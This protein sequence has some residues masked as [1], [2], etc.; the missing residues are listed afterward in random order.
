M[1]V[2][3][4]FLVV[5]AAVLAAPAPAAG[6][7]TPE[8][9]ADRA[10]AAHAAGD[11]AALATIANAQDP[12]A[13]FV[14]EK[15]L[16]DG[17]VE[18]A[19]AL[20][21][22]R[23]NFER[24]SLEAYVAWRAENPARAAVLAAIRE[25]EALPEPAPFLARIE[26]LLAEGRGVSHVAL[27][28]IRTAAVARLERGVGALGEAMLASA[29]AADELGWHWRAF[30]SYRAAFQ[31]FYTVNAADK[32]ARIARAMLRLAQ[33]SKDETEGF[34][35]HQMEAF[36]LQTLGQVER[37]LEHA[38]KS[39]AYAQNKHETRNALRVVIMMHI[40]LGNAH[41][42]LRKLKRLNQLDHELGD[43]RGAVISSTQLARYEA[44]VGRLAQALARIEGVLAYTKR[45]GGAHADVYAAHMH[46]SQIT[47]TLGDPK[48][49][50]EHIKLARAAE[51]RSREA[52]EPVNYD[53]FQLD[54]SE[55]L[56]LA[57]MER[58]EEAAVLSR[59]VVEGRTR[60]PPAMRL[61]D[62]IALAIDL[63]YLGRHEE[64]ARYFDEAEALLAPEL[65][66]HLH[67]RFYGVKAS[68]LVLA[69]KMDEALR[70]AETGEHLS[71]DERFNEARQFC[72]AAMG[73]VWYERGQM[74]KAT[75]AFD[76]M[77]GLLLDRS[78]MLPDRMGATFRSARADKAKHV[79]VSYGLEAA[80][81]SGDAA[82]LFRLAER[83]SSVALRNRL[84]TTDVAEALAPE[85]REKELEL[86]EAETRAVGRLR[87][88]KGEERAQA[89]TALGTVRKDL[90]RHRERMR[91]EQAAA[92]QVIDPAIDTLAETQARLA[93]DEALVLYAEGARTLWAI[94]ADRKTARIVEIGPPANVTGTLERVVLE[95]PGSD[96][97]ADVAT[98]RSAL[99]EP[100][101]LPAKARRVSV[102]PTGVL[103]F[104]PY[105]AV[106]VDREVTLL[107]SATTARLLGAH[108]RR[109]RGTL[110]V[111]DPESA[112]G[113]R[114]PGSA[115]EA[116][117]IG[118]EVLVGR[119][120][121]EAG[122]EAALAKRPRWRAVHIACHGLIDPLHPLRSALSLTPAG[123]DDGLWTVSELLRTRVPTDLAVLGSCSTGRGKSFSR[124]GV[125]GFV[126]AF[127]VAGARQVVVSLW[128][129]DDKATSALLRRFHEE[130]K[131]GVA[132]ATALQR[133][134]AWLRT[135]PAWAHPAYWA[136]WQIWGPR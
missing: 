122:I 35:A 36:R 40:R 123:D 121:S 60:V 97:K 133:A 74:R 126:H 13:W 8:A 78:A 108:E 98:L 62:L 5:L 135:Q 101:K 25:W 94:V 112:D 38:E 52:G 54:K 17:Y 85:L 128:D 114:L 24:K 49:A 33:R 4:A 107:P 41:V 96:W 32:M 1:R 56:A 14:L 7:E 119:A 67:V 113:R 71:R 51:T 102:V 19:R 23:Q 42:V 115:V 21:S 65:E 12:E 110:A 120:A 109:G 2:R 116:K 93:A 131:D 72:L 81:R 124:E 69:G 18:V 103:A 118:D 61:N 39:L 76:Q 37:A 127:F 73:R 3:V 44:Q 105:A 27:A 26:P 125:L 82:V 88:A 134:Q 91:A 11:A 9:A 80:A 15:L 45:H 129:V 46:A 29:S 10:R 63:A 28:E 99:V 83:S 57:M 48:R 136:A 75:E 16:V 132:P 47:R 117:A 70:A 92:A 58:Y 68:A 55:A 89:L 111:G 87:R 106:L 104:V 30:H 77:L 66:A 95:A 50:L 59:R 31:R 79:S 6:S 130:W 86:Q 22:K 64:A 20:A 53:P 84:G 34:I 100:L 90:D 43:T